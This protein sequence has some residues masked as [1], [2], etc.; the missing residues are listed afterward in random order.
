MENIRNI[1]CSRVLIGAH[2]AQQWCSWNKCCN[3]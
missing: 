2:L 3:L 1:V